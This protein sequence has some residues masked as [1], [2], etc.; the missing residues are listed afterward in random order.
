MTQ[1]KEYTIIRTVF[2]IIN[3]GGIENLGEDVSSLINDIF[4]SRRT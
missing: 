4:S 1:H 3:S 2:E